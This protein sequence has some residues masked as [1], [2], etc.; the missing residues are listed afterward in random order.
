MKAPENASEIKEKFFNQLSECTHLKD[1]KWIDEDRYGFSRTVSFNARGNTYKIIWF[2]NESIL[3]INDEIQIRFN[4]IEISNTWPNNFKTNIHFSLNGNIVAV[5][6]I[7][8]SKT[9]G[10]AH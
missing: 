1:V 6:P 2:W 8:A 3:S 7:E 5:L 4:D 9:E 10:V